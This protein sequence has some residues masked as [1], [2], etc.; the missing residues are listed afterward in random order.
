MDFDLF[1]VLLRALSLSLEALA[2][3]G[4]MF[5][6]LAGYAELGGAAGT[7]YSAYSAVPLF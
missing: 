5:L 6:W 2:V 3:G 1:G 4:V 7:S